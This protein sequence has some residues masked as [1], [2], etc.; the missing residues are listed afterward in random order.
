MIDD[1]AQ[2]GSNIKKKHLKGACLRIKLELI[3]DIKVHHIGTKLLHTIKKPL[4]PY[5]I[6]SLKYADNKCRVYQKQHR[7]QST[8]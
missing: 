7:N 5:T 3:G 6:K 2:L 1:S 8:N 4:G